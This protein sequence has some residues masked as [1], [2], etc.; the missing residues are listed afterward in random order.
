M[1]EKQKGFRSS[2]DQAHIGIKSIRDE[3]ELGGDRLVTIVPNAGVSQTFGRQIKKKGQVSD[4]LALCFFSMVGDV[5]FEPT[6]P[7]V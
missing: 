2:S 7:A 4:D 6:T 5:G 1:R 3:A